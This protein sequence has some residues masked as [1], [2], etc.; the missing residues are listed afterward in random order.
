MEQPDPLNLAGNLCARVCHDLAGTAGALSGMLDLL[1]EAPDP[2]A[3]AL[4]RDCAQD[5]S[6]RLRLM[7]A[8]WGADAEVPALE[9]LLPGLPNATRLTVNLASLAPLG[10]DPQRQLAACL[11]ILAATALPLGGT[12]HLAGTAARLTLQL[13]GRR[14]AWP[15]A[16]ASDPRGVPAAMASLR[17]QS[18]GLAVRIVSDTAL[19]VAARSHTGAE[20]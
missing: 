1:A 2:E 3:L 14:A 12:I 19:E 20:P 10:T 4:A 5:L 17:A 16:D 18:L 9:T 15:A 11:L 8:A 6:A 7:R 13:E